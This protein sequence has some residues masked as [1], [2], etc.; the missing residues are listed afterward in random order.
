MGM[1]RREGA[2]GMATLMRKYSSALRIASLGYGMYT[3]GYMSY[4]I[5]RR[6]TNSRRRRWRKSCSDGEPIKSGFSN[7][8]R[9]Q[10]KITLY[11]DTPV[12][13]W[14]RMTRSQG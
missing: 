11:T 1:P 13:L 2:F 6:P 9:I 3:H 14:V 7:K 5:R 12:N 10:L 8:G 4:V